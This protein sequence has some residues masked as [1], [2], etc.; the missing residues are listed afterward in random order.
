MSLRRSDRI[1]FSDSALDYLIG[2]CLHSLVTGEEPSPQVWSRIEDRIR[3]D[4]RVTAP[5]ACA[6]PKTLLQQLPSVSLALRCLV[7][8]GEGAWQ[9]MITVPKLAPE[10]GLADGMVFPFCQLRAK[11]FF[12]LS[13]SWTCLT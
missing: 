4:S 10:M 6:W 5:D 13:P 12:D 2:W 7:S 3:S 8:V 11:P 9:Q 1:P